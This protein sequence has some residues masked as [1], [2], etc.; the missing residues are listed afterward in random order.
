MSQAS[1]SG[2]LDWLLETCS[3][4][5]AVGAAAD[6]PYASEP[7]ARQLIEHG[8]V[9]TYPGTDCME[10][11]AVWWRRYT[12]K[13]QTNQLV[14]DCTV[15]TQVEFA[16]EIRRCV[17]TVTKDGAPSVQEESDANRALSDDVQTMWRRIT[18]DVT[19]GV[20]PDGVSCDRFRML[21]AEPTPPAGGLAGARITLVITL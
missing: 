10:L 17:P 21:G 8:F 20:L 11:L 19:N 7:P 2:I 3:D 12:P 5:L 1:V 13:Q 16:A 14:Q 9:A 18:H 4:A 15:I 6:P